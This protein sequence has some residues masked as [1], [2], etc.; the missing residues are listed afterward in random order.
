MRFEVLGGLR[1]LRGAEE[2]S[3]GGPKQK[4]VLAALLLDAGRVI[5]KER[6]IEAVWGDDPAESAA[7]TLQVYV[8]SL[9]T[10]LGPDLIVAR[11]SGYAI[12]LGENTLDLAEFDEL[13]AEASR[14][15]DS[16]RSDDAIDA[17]DRALALFRGPPLVEFGETAYFAPDAARFADADLSMR[18]TAH[19]AHLSR[20]RD[21]GAVIPGLERD[22]ATHPRNERLHALLMTALY[23]SGRQ[24]EALDT[25]AALRTRLVDELGL[26][27]SPELR[28]LEQRMIEQDPTL[29]VA[30][31]ALDATRTVQ[32]STPATE[33]RGQLQI[34]DQTISLEAV[35]TTI[36]RLPDRS[37]V[38]SDPDVSRRHAE[39]R[40]ASGGFLL[41]DCESTNGVSV[42]GAPIQPGDPRRRRRDRGRKHLTHVHRGRLTVPVSLGIDGLEPPSSSP[43]EVTPRS[44]APA[45]PTSTA[46]WP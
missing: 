28:A 44:I 35:V 26:D 38:L 36:G 24:A 14:A 11:G 8:S 22:V 2:V 5:P 31:S 34:G 25:Y 42:N 13:S 12:E 29:M 15:L 40:R 46:T 23:R 32:I 3:L 30:R 41:V 19:E 16:G 27:P 37:V 4:T 17:A 43:E 1:V 7:R 39:I 9:R 21:L 6:L 20:D 33:H 18:V 45:N 10:A